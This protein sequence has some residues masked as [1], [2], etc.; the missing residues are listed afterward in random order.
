MR[1]TLLWFFSALVLIPWLTRAQERNLWESIFVGDVAAIQRYLGSGGD[2]DGTSMPPFRGGP[3]VGEPVPLL[4]LALMD[5]EQA[6]ALM[7]LKAGARFDSLEQPL[8]VVATE[9]L[10][11]V[12]AYVVTEDPGRLTRAIATEIGRDIVVSPAARGYADVLE[13]VLTEGERQQIKWDP[14]VLT[15]ALATAISFRQNDAARL[16]LRHGALPTGMVLR[17]AARDGSPGMVRALLALGVDPSSR[18]DER[19]VDPEV[20][21]RTPLEYAWNRYNSSPSQREPARLIIRSL[22]DAGARNEHALTRAQLIPT[23]LLRADTVTDPTEKLLFAARF[24]FLD[25]VVAMLRSRGFD[26]RTRGEAAKVALVEQENDVARTLIQSGVPINDGVLHAAARGN[27]PAIV[28]QL[29]SLGADPTLVSDGLTPI[30]HWW[31]RQRRGFIG[32]GGHYVLHELLIAGAPACWLRDYDASL[33][34]VTHTFLRSD[35][36]ECWPEQEPARD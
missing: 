2:P 1:D 4:R 33:D 32:I 23:D 17:V 26:S 29:I 16:L 10:D 7:L 34:L 28:R 27:S 24:G 20:Q 14:A 8:L 11:Q 5:R 35:A 36:P 9:G 12:L 25:D 18:L 6:I 15:A 3:P 21:A 22:S 30:E 19:D 13:F 31:E